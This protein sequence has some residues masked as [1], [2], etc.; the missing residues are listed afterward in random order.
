MKIGI[1]YQPQLKT[2][3]M[4][5]LWKDITNK[6]N[7]IAPQITEGLLP[8]VTE[9]EVKD[10]EERLQIKLP[11]NFI[12]F[13]KIHNGQDDATP[14][15]IDGELLLSFEEIYNQW[16]IWDDLQRNKHFETDNGEPFESDPEKGI[17]NVWWNSKWIPFTYDGS[18]NHLCLDLDPDS[19]GNYGQVIRMWHDDSNRLLLAKSF[20]DW[21]KDYTKQLQNGNLVN[22]EDYFAIIN[23]QD[24]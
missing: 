4:Q 21:V 6:L 23:K 7:A 17:K 1:T 19:G 9:T 8:G 2:K 13:Y 15:M 10:L 24:A 5:T 3:P 11:N 22:S 14:W 20:T 18:G 12:D 16:S